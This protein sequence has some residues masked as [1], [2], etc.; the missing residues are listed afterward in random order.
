MRNLLRKIIFSVFGYKVTIE[1]SNDG[2][3]WEYIA[4]VRARKYNKEYK[5]SNYKVYSEYRFVHKSRS[6]F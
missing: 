6:N 2:E 5:I 3:N 1:G 4:T